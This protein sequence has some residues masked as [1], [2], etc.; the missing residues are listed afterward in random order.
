M[1]ELDSLSA[2]DRSEVDGLICMHLALLG[3]I[4]CFLTY[5]TV[6]CLYAYQVHPLDSCVV[7]VYASRTGS[8]AG[9]MDVFTHEAIT[10]S[11]NPAKKGRE[12]RSRTKA[13]RFFARMEGA[14][15]V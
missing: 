1:G 6:I 12:R 5:T 14:Y 15:G 11:A 4:A 13:S 9:Y 7:Y 2:P 10:T 3:C 8:T